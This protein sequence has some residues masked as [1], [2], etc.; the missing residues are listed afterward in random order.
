MSGLTL[1]I[2][3][4][5][6]IKSVMG[7]GLG[8]PGPPN[9]MTGGGHGPPGPPGSYA[10]AMGVLLSVPHYCVGL[11]KCIEWCIEASLRSVA[12]K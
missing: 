1:P 2:D 5:I 10:T 8:G 9:F 11:Y 4:W 3:A 12:F 7:L 6:Y